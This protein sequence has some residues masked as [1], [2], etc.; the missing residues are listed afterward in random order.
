MTDVPV[1]E[2]APSVGEVL[3]SARQEF[4]HLTGRPVES[5]S[6]IRRCEGGWRVTVEV[7]ELRRVPDSTSVLASYELQ[8]DSEGSVLEFERTSRFY[9]NRATDEDAQ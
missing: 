8:L 6:A 2:S 4:E 5:V 3:T 1:T 7:L 9:R